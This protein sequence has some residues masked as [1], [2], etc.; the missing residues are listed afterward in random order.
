M[1]YT[2]YRVYYFSKKLEEW[3]WYANWEYSKSEI[4]QAIAEIIEDRL[5]DNVFEGMLVTTSEGIPVQLDY[6]PTYVVS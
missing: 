2:T 4:N 6:K 1:P 5:I 3:I